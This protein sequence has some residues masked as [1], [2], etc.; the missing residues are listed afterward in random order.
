MYSNT[1]YTAYTSLLYVYHS[2]RWCVQ[3]QLNNALSYC[4]ESWGKLYTIL[5]QHSKIECIARSGR[6]KQLCCDGH[7]E[8]VVVLCCALVLSPVLCHIAKMLLQHC[9]I[10]L[11]PLLVKYQK[12]NMQFMTYECHSRLYL[13]QGQCS[14]LQQQYMSSKMVCMCVR[15]HLLAT[16]QQQYMPPLFISHIYS[17][18]SMDTLRYIQLY[19]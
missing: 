2:S 18:L 16:L 19:N 11:K 10:C 5:P 15:V 3:Q 13:L 8:R 17:S 7:S 14:L 1:S 4:N 12:V 6:L 9:L